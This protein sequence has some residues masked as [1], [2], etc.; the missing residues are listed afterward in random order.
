MNS[1]FLKYVIVCC[2]GV[3]A[4]CNAF[5]ST[6]KILFS[7]IDSACPQGGSINLMRALN[8]GYD[9][10]FLFGECT[11]E[12]EIEKAIGIPYSQK[13]FL[14]D[15]EYK[16]ILLNN[17]NIV[18]DNNFYCK[19]VEF[20]FYN[21]KYHYPSNNSWYCYVWTDSI[22]IASPKE[23]WDGVFYQLRPSN[24]D[25]FTISENDTGS[26]IC[27]RKKIT[28]KTSKPYTAKKHI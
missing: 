9:T 3:L 11:N 22:F 23:K 20:F 14:Q 26:V 28:I 13:T 5:E 8:V 21:T 27:P 12:K 6:D 16:L 10:A 18:Y 19:R 15:S 1:R 7:Y 24:E 4:S 25:G 2:C 17:H